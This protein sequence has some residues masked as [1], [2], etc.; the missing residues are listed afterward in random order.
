MNICMGNQLIVIVRC[1]LL[2]LFAAVHKLYNLLGHSIAAS[3]W[4]HWNLQRK[5]CNWMEKRPFKLKPKQK[6]NLN[7]YHF[8][9]FN[10]ARWKSNCYCT[11]QQRR[12]QTAATHNDESWNVHSNYMTWMRP[13]L[14]CIGAHKINGYYGK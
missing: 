12:R 10:W 9:N 13:M 3:G 7:L 2:F 4:A 1:V 14:N 5:M 6:V 8:V 11:E